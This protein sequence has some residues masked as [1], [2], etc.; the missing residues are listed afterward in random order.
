[1]KVLR[2]LLGI[3]FFCLI[4]STFCFQMVSA[5]GGGGGSGGGHSSSGSSHSSS[6]TGSQSSSS[7]SEPSCSNFSECRTSYSI[8]FIIYLSI[9]S[10]GYLRNKKYHQDKLTIKNI[11]LLLIGPIAFSFFATISGLFGVIIL[12]F[13][14]YAYVIKK[15][16]SSDLTK[17]TILNEEIDHV[18]KE[19]ITALFLTFQKAWSSSD[20]EALKKI[21]TPSH[22]ERIALELLV[23]QKEGRINLME[24]VSVDNDMTLVSKNESGE[25]FSISIMAQASD[26]LTERLTD[27]KLL[28]D[29]SSFT[30]VWDFV[31]KGDAVLLDA[32]HQVDEEVN[33]VPEIRDWATSHSFF[34]NPD[35]GWLMLP[36]KGVLFQKS[37]FGKTDI[38]N[39]CI[40]NYKNNI[41]E[42]YTIKF[43]VATYLIGQTILPKEYKN[44]LIR[45]K[46]FFEMAPT[47]LKKWTLES[48]AFNDEFEVYYA[49]GDNITMLELLNPSF[50]EYIMKL[51]FILNLELVGNFLYFYTK[52]I[53]KADYDKLLEIISR[54]FEE[55]KM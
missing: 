43:D 32:I 16:T 12:G 40:G 6:H 14:I 31:H 28:H 35:F 52:D 55:M 36:N 2:T 5:R 20:Y 26:I 23:L 15:H 38:D 49:E 29:T 19:K 1:M 46:K 51:P 37:V 13:L 30:E 11:F 41:V 9:F 42:L 8:W 45:R 27:K 53:E 24:N 4:A 44:V 10:L 25:T 33:V 34:Y 50:M 3:F 7:G 47:G 54:A 39:H 48:S 17:A 21:L 22:Y 18:T